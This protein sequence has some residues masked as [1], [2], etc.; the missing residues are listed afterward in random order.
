MKLS[1]SLIGRLGFLAA[2]V[3]VLIVAGNW[4]AQRWTG[5][6]VTSGLV[7]HWTFDSGTIQGSTVQD[8]SGNGRNGTM[9]MGAA[10]L[11]GCMQFDGVDDRVELPNLDRQTFTFAGWVRKDGIGLGTPT[12]MISRNNGGIGI[13]YIRLGSPNLAPGASPGVISVSP[14]GGTPGVT[15]NE[16]PKSQTQ[17]GSGE[18]FHHITATFNGLTTKIYI[19]GVLDSA[20][21]LPITYDSNGGTYLLGWRDTVP[22]GYISALKGLMDDVRMYDRV[23]TQSEITQLSQIAPSCAAN[24]S[25]GPST[26]LLGHWT[27]D[28]GTIQG[29]TVQDI[30]GNGKN[31]TMQQGASAP[32]GCMQFDGV[33]DQVTVPNFDRQVFTFATWAKKEPGGSG[34]P[35]LINSVQN[36]GW[37]VGYWD[38]NPDGSAQNVYLSKIHDSNVQTQTAM[39]AGTFYHIAVS[40][41]GAMA[42][43]Y[44][45][46]ALTATQP[47]QTTF[48]S[49]GA[50][51]VMGYRPSLQAGQITNAFKGWMDDTRIYD[52]VLTAAEISQLAQIAPNCGAS[53]GGSSQTSSAAAT[54]GQSSSGAATFCTAAPAI[55]QT[56]DVQRTDLFAPARPSQYSH[57]PMPLR[58]IDGDGD[59]DIWVFR[60]SNNWP[61]VYHGY[62]S[63]NLVSLKNDGNGNFTS[64]A[65][66]S[67][68]PSWNVG[69][70]GYAYFDTGDVSNDGKPDI[71]VFEMQSGA[72]PPGRLR[73]GRGNGDGTFQALGSLPQ[74]SIPTN[75]FFYRNLLQDVTGDGKPDV[76]LLGQEFAGF[77]NNPQSY[78]MSDIWVYP[79]LSGGG[80][81]AAVRSDVPLTPPYAGGWGWS[82]EPHFA[83]VTSDGKL[84]LLITDPQAQSAS[85]YVHILRGGGDGSFTAIRQIDVSAD[86]EIRLMSTGD[87][88]GDG[89]IDF[90]AAFHVYPGKIRMYYGDGTGNFTP[91]PLGTVPVAVDDHT[92][93]MRDVTGD[94]KADVVIDGYYM[95]ANN[96]LVNV[97]AIL[98]AGPGRTVVNREVPLP[99]SGSLR[100]LEDINGDGVADFIIEYTTAAN[101]LGVAAFATQNSC[102]HPAGS[103]SG[104]SSVSSA[105]WVPPNVQCTMASPAFTEFPV[106]TGNARAWGITQAPDGN[107]WFVENLGNKVGYITPTGSV[108]EFPLASRSLP[109]DIAVGHDGNLWFTEEEGLKI[110]KITPTG[111]LT[112]YSAFGFYII[113]GITRGPDGNMW[114]VGGGKIGKITPAGV[115]TIY[116]IPNPDPQE[117]I[118]HIATGSDGN[119]WFTEIVAN[120]IGKITPAGVITEYPI[121]TTNSMPYGITLGPDGNIW[122]TEWAGKKIGKI[123]PAGVI[124]EYPLSPDGNSGV[125]RDIVAG[126]DGHLWFGIAAEPVN[127][128]GRITTAG[129]VTKYALPQRLDPA[130]IAFGPDGNIWLTEELSNN[131]GRFNPCQAGAGSSQ[132]GTSSSGGSSSV[133][134]AC[135]PAARYLIDV[136]IDGM[137]NGPD[138]NL[139]VAEPQTNKISKVTPSGSITRYNVPTP[140][141]V[142]W[143]IALGP[144]NNMW[145]TESNADKI[146]RITPSGT[147][148]EFPVPTSEAGLR[149]IVTGP[150][151]NL[152]FTEAQ[153]DKIGR[154]TTGGVVTEY[155]LPAGSSP[156]YMVVGPDN[157]IWFTE[158]DSNKI[159][160]ITTAGVI[161]HFSVPTANSV[162]WGITAGPDGNI[163]FTERNTDK[164]GKITTSGVVTEYPLP[165]GMQPWHIVTGTDGAL[166]FTGHNSQKVGRM[167]TSGALT[168]FPITSNNNS[169]GLLTDIITGPDGNLWYGDGSYL[170]KMPLSCRVGITSSSGSSGQGSSGSA[171]STQ[172]VPTACV[173]S[174]TP[175]RFPTPTANSKPNGMTRGPD[176]NLWFLEDQAS[177][178][179]RLTP[180]GVMTEF[181][182]PLS[183]ESG[184]N[185]LVTGPDGNL[186]FTSYFDKKIGKVTTAG[187]VT[188][189][190]LPTGESAK[191]SSIAAGPDGNLWFTAAEGAGGTL[192]AKVGRITT[193]GVIT[194]YSATPGSSPTSIAAG[195][196][197]NLWFTQGG[198]AKIGKI[199]T[200]GVITEYPLLSPS[201][202]TVPGHLVPGP[203][204]NLWFTQALSNRI[205]R[206]T[207]A[208]V[209]TDYPLHANYIMSSEIRVGPDG[210]IWFLEHNGTVPVIGNITTAGVITDAIPL[211]LS[212]GAGI[213]A[214]DFASNGSLWFTDYQ[215]GLWQIGCSGVSSA[216]AQSSSG[217]Q[218][219]GIS[220]SGQGTSSSGTGSSGTGSSGNSASACSAAGQFFEYPILTTDGRPNHITMGP[221]NNM[222]FTEIAA[223]KIGRITPSGVVTEYAVPT[224]QANVAGIAT[225]PDGNLWFTEF[226]GKIGRITTGG[227]VTEYALPSNSQPFG[228]ARGPDDNMWFTQPGTNKI[229]RITPSGAISHYAIPTANSQ[230]FG[231]TAG[232]DGNLWF[233]ENTASKIGRITPS[234]TITEYVLPSNGMPRWITAGPDGALWFTQPVAGKIG[235]IT[236]AGVITE[237]PAPAANS[238]NGIVAGSDGNVWYTANSANKIGRITPAGVVTEYAVPTA[239][240]QP[241]SIAAGP[242]GYV[243]FTE[244]AA[245]KIGKLA[246]G[247]ACSSASGN[248]S[249]QS[250]SGGASSTSVGFCGPVCG[251]NIVMVPEQCDTGKKNSDTKADAC[252]M[253]CKRA[254]CG[255]NV[256]DTAEQCDDGNAVAGDGCSL[257]CT[258]ESSN[259]GNGKLDA[260]EDCDD[261]NSINTDA[262]NNSCRIVCTAN[263]Q[264]PNAG[265]C[266]NGQCPR[267]CGDRTVQL[268]EQCDDGNTVDTDSCTNSCTLRCT[269]NA[270]CPSGQC[271]GGVCTS[272]C[273]NGVVDAGE[274][275]D[276]GN[277]RDGDACSARCAI[278]CTAGNQ[279]PSGQCASGTCVPLCGN[280]TVN[281][282]EQCD[283]GNTVDT[284]ACSNLCLINCSSN[285]QCASG[286]C[287]GGH[288]VL[289]GDN[290]R[291]ST[292][293]CD[294][295]NTRDNDGCSRTCRT[296]R[297][298][299][300]LPMDG[301]SCHCPM[302]NAWDAALQKCVVQPGTTCGAAGGLVCGCDGR[303]Y[304]NT[305][306]AGLAGIKQ[307]TNGDCGG[308]ASSRTGSVGSASSAGG[309]PYACPS[310]A[311]CDVALASG[312]CMMREFVCPAGQQLITIRAC[313]AGT[314]AGDC[315]QCVPAGSASSGVSSA[316]SSGGSSVAVSVTSVSSAGQSSS[317]SLLS[318]CPYSFSASPAC[319]PAEYPTRT[320]EDCLSSQC[321]RCMPVPT[322][323]ASCI[324]SDGGYD[325]ETAG[326][327]SYAGPLNI[328]DYCEGN[329]VREG[330]CQDGGPAQTGISCDYEGR[331][332]VNGACM[333]AAEAAAARAG[334]EDSDGNDF[335][336]AGSVVTPGQTFTDSCINSTQVMEHYCSGSTHFSLTGNCSG[337]TCQNGACL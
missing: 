60:G 34:T 70:D 212:A 216:S 290:K 195:P 302:G 262:C 59:L 321:C 140:N 88:D 285:G 62:Q 48:Q 42:K 235:R 242:D 7:A 54:S 189:Y 332:C 272:T 162:P 167:T 3:G 209:V 46:G 17:I 160:R 13:G 40:Y 206:I 237:Y 102:L 24:T 28:S 101:D 95:G 303:T 246:V 27:Y 306:V 32:N 47:Y 22:A 330:F 8:V 192:A 317:T 253:N 76:I 44:V 180:S 29:S 234:G 75:V 191:P 73:F 83:D 222:W 251:D 220:S 144:D 126:P 293:E 41:D 79:Q 1:R 171:A 196:D 115:I 143:R 5:Q 69:L 269:N 249:G 319:P 218:S 214:M 114:F 178:I 110:G 116:T 151:G 248:S 322:P 230:P 325:Y 320:F 274:Q 314:C 161:T 282:G 305:C 93:G 211:T 261:G 223:N 204:G 213:A 39:A 283:D 252:R 6:V 100:S 288:C 166:W 331:S 266:L 227:A 267:L 125:P 294:D 68:T 296:E 254:R 137:E 313:G 56:F 190:P 148:T 327:V 158:G 16:I 183:A 163:W 181:P 85:K 12:I 281:S 64:P 120:K 194:L 14:A 74:L 150:D 217:G 118:Y 130:H 121:P 200:S 188:V 43:F 157:N 45:N 323:G 173:L 255:D 67:I 99:V 245:N 33:N 179:G 106:P 50:D 174:G 310:P 239:G 55:A 186:W 154:M 184:L 25:I 135:T 176:G 205:G 52:R 226:S 258:R 307:V 9:Q 165:A 203:D 247:G 105:A 124:S 134:G 263:S 169:V 71:M 289:C 19:D 236:T 304:P 244:N 292:E 187:V 279:C 271:T 185:S 257:T 198:N 312:R 117:S 308:S 38:N 197:G 318:Q 265:V 18:S 260:G 11:N 82:I 153:K 270:Q 139:W 80:F 333:T 335:L 328:F 78:Q 138:G 127:Q 87:A 20:T 91:G 53:A 49:N 58:D 65:P 61:D 280:G 129:V 219:S 286:Q 113:R 122:F 182:L 112:E 241:Y 177:K 98:A 89:K 159:G 278:T 141:A 72:Q 170:D 152:W 168:E 273:G 81:G 215:A 51:Y 63:V 201:P 66:Y 104:G 23:L 275:C 142:P 136:G 264:C 291:Q 299:Q 232:P 334:C 111:A 10:P 202:S 225:G 228:M 295:G 172:S 243:W 298:W 164:V 155:P 108:T 284:D 156:N 193:G 297:G 147:V 311:S 96:A 109:H 4:A 300:C 309:D 149:D 103:S 36:L 35:L 77:W 315:M 146:G 240:S 30:S 133:A 210:K 301:D 132:G 37:G 224:P 238:A 2:A 329:L 86:G 84:D 324:D 229:G 221:D 316:Q 107:M 231:I 207:P 256:L 57:N 90:A 259:C 15:V 119:L 268:P 21:N 123:T 97:I 276:D 92:M 175:A 287:L 336:V 233:V 31:G 94:G 145:F 26:G 326:S 128:I 199:T 277:N 208:G 337:R 131:I 250:T